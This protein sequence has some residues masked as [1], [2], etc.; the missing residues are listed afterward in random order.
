MKY[1]PRQGISEVW[2]IRA[3]GPGEEE[4]ESLDVNM[5]G[6]GEEIGLWRAAGLWTLL[7]DILCIILLQADATVQR[8]QN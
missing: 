8:V 6:D 5:K 3:I 1:G 4:D 7:P 2:N